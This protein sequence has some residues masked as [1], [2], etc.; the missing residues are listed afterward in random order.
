MAKPSFSI[1][2][3]AVNCAARLL[4]VRVKGKPMTLLQCL[5]C[6]SCLLSLA[7]GQF[8]GKVILVDVADVLNR[9]PANPLG[10]YHFDILEPDIGIEPLFFSFLP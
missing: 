7:H 8:I 6:L 9:F 5:F 4:R 1:G 2:L 3:S 10:G